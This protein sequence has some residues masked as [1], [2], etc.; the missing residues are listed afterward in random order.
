MDPFI[1]KWLLSLIIGSFWVVISTVI[2]EKISGKIGGLILGLP[3]TAVVSLLFI[4]LTQDL[5]SVLKA[6]KIVPFMSGFY[7]FFFLTYLIR[8]KKG[9]MIGLINALIIW[10]LFAFIALLF[11]IVGA[12]KY[13]LDAVLRRREL[14]A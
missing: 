3:T 9:F 2:A 7:C 8:S 13:G 5:E 6:S 14:N 10:F 1:T 4:G 11:I 12:G